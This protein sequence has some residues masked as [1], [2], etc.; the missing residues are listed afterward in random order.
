MAQSDA[1]RKLDA[2]V[3]EI[4]KAASYGLPSPKSKADVVERPELGR[5]GRYMWCDSSLIHPTPIGLIIPWLSPCKMASTEEVDVFTAQAKARGWE[6]GEHFKILKCGV[7]GIRQPTLR[8]K[9]V[10][11]F[12]AT[13]AELPP[14]WFWT[15]EESIAFFGLA[16]GRV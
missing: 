12:V 15:E 10:K 11:E 8:S 4:K 5:D 7:C 13:G 9:T 1:L 16:A 2:A 14:G 3:V 6:R